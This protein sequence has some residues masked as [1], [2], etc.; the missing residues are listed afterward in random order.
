MIFN[1]LRSLKP[2]FVDDICQRVHSVSELNNRGNMYLLIKD[3]TEL[4][5]HDITGIVRDENIVRSSCYLAR[6]EDVGIIPDYGHLLPSVGTTIA[7]VFGSK[8]SFEKA[9][10]SHGGYFGFNPVSKS[11]DLTSSEYYRSGKPRHFTSRI[12]SNDF[13]PI[14]LTSDKNDRCLSHW[15]WGKVP[16]LRMAEREIKQLSN[17]VFIATYQPQTW[18]VEILNSILPSLRQIPITI[19]DSPVVL[20]KMFVVFGSDFWVFDPEYVHFLGML[21]HITR[22]DVPKKPRRLF[23]SRSD[24]ATRRIVNE[25]EIRKVLTDHG[26]E[27]V[28]MTNLHFLQQVKILAECEKLIFIA[29]SHGSLLPFVNKKCDVGIITNRQCADELDGWERF[30]PNMGRHSL[31]SF[32]AEPDQSNHNSFNNDLHLDPDELK[33]HL[34]NFV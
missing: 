23:I 3:S 25:I 19:I 11:F 33:H 8:H 21:A 7:D 16:Q 29:G 28:I 34:A 10:A 18:Q 1:S 22:T 6:I 12:L 30:A 26:F 17:P 27:T 2:Q 24:A 32:F 9:M 20:D 13:T 4:H 5:L 31:V 15:L 14:L